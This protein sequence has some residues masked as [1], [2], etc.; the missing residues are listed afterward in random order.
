MSPDHYKALSV[1]SRMVQRGLNRLSPDVRA[2]VVAMQAFERDHPPPRREDFPPEGIYDLRPAFL[3][4]RREWRED[5]LEAGRAAQ[6]AY[7]R[8]DQ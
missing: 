7:L 8:R 5:Q 4:A 3:A 6:N 2:A 1:R